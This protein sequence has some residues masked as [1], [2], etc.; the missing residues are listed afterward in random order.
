MENK[1]RALGANSPA[2]PDNRGAAPLQRPRRGAAIHHA[3]AAL[4][5]GS[6]RPS[7]PPV[8]AP[9]VAL[10]TGC[11]APSSTRKGRRTTAASPGRVGA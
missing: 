10:G 8:A 7:Q 2:G 4:P 3:C 5:A 1:D 11:A 6:D 9:T